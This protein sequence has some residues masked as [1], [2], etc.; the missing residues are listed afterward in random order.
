MSQISESTMKSRCIEGLGLDASRN[1]QVLSDELDDLYNGISEVTL[2]NNVLLLRASS[3]LSLSLVWSWVDRVESLH[4]ENI[5][6]KTCGVLSAFLA[7]SSSKS[8]LV[9]HPLLG[10]IYSS[11]CRSFARNLHITM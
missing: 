3:A 2:Y 7:A 6:L 11:E 4:D 8:K 1:L 5:S 10:T 9:K